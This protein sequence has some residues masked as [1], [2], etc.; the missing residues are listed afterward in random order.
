MHLFSN[1]SQKNSKC[2]KNISDT[3]SYRLDYH[4][5]TF[6][7]TDHRFIPAFFMLKSL[8]GF[9]SLNKAFINNGNRTERSP[10]WSVIIRVI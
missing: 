5:T 4:L 8:I 9:F 1:R 3:L 10:I 7:C 2:G 6:S